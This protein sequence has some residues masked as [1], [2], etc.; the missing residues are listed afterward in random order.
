MNLAIFAGAL[1]LA[2][3]P[4][5]AP[6]PGGPPDPAAARQLVFAQ[7]TSSGSAGFIDIAS[8]HTVGDHREAVVI[9]VVGARPA[10]GEPSHVIARISVDCRANTSQ[11]LGGDVMDEDDHKVDELPNRPEDLGVLDPVTRALVCGGP[12]APDH[13]RVFPTPA[14]AASWARTGGV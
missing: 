9:L 12:G 14:A 11:F 8:V 2:A 7:R 3:E 4:A 6:A 10:R 5:A 1:I 13:P